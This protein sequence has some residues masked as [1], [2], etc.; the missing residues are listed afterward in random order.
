LLLLHGFSG[1][2]EDFADWWDQLA[3]RGW[4][5]VVPDLRGHGAS[6][7]PSG[8]GDYSLDIFEADVIGL[9]DDLGWDRFVLL[10]HSM[11]GM[12]GQAIAIHTPER[13]E[14]LVLMDTIAGAVSG[15]RPMLFVFRAATR[16]FGMKALARLARKPPPRS[17]ASVRRLYAERPDYGAVVQAKVLATSPVMARVMMAELSRR[18]DHLRELRSLELPVRVIAGEFDMPGFVDGSK[19]MADAIPGA[20][21]VVLDGAAH[22]PQ[23][24][25]PVEWWAALTDFLDA[26]SAAS[27]HQHTEGEG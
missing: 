7:H 2:K 23:F 21:L 24:E 11:G 14:A 17:P 16:L 1:A 6:D 3:E 15:G 19:A 18:T 27:P 26:L 9:V 20:T 12:I 13:L 5:V 22:S 4:H 25:T 10:G 8:A